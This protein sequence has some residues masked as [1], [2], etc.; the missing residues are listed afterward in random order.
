MYSIKFRSQ[1]KALFLLCSFCLLSESILSQPVFI[2]LSNHPLIFGISICWVYTKGWELGTRDLEVD[3]VDICLP[4]GVKGKKR[5]KSIKLSVIVKC[6][7]NYD[8]AWYGWK[9]RSMP[10]TL[11]RIQQVFLEEALELSSTR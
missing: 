6:D 8:G 2:H 10:L 9:T 11:E 4:S 7:K 1:T 3:N 5:H